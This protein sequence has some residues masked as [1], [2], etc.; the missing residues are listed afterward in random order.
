MYDA[1]AFPSKYDDVELTVGIGAQDALT[2]QLAV[3]YKDPVILSA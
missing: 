3:P 1:L 2:A